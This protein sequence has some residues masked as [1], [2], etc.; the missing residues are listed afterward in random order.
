VVDVRARNVNHL[1]RARLHDCNLCVV[2]GRSMEMI[3]M[4]RM[5][6]LNAMSRRA[7]RRRRDRLNGLNWK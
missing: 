6:A 2:A 4:L 1:V 3:R 7:R 5:C